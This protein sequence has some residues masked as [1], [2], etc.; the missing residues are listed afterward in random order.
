MPQ[1]PERPFAYSVS[2][3]DFLFSVW[4]TLASALDAA[5]TRFS[6]PSHTINTD[7]AQKEV[8][9][10]VLCTPDKSAWITPEQAH[11][12]RVR[13]VSVPQW[14]TRGVDGHRTLRRRERE[15]GTGPLGLPWEEPMKGPHHGSSWSG[16]TQT[17]ISTADLC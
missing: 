6:A 9:F 3:L 13:S 5:R 15:G 1:S 14:A 16:K 10:D 12:S 17:G 4:P 7:G 8:E 2:K 11:A